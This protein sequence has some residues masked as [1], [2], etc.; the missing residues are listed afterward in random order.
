[1]RSGNRNQMLLDNQYSYP[2]ASD[3]DSP[4]SRKLLP[5]EIKK[6][7]DNVANW[8]QKIEIRCSGTTILVIPEHLIPIPRSQVSYGE[9][10]LQN[11]KN[12]GFRD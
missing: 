1:M 10:N 7:L 3:Y 5:Q 4:I 11:L 8:D 6:K 9:V 12:G 2:G